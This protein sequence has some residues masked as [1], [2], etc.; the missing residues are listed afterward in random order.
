LSAESLEDRRMMAVY[1]VT[2]LGDGP[3]T[4]AGQQPGT[5]RQAIFD[6]NW[7]SGADI[8]VF[9]PNLTGTIA[10]AEG[11]LAITDPLTLTGPGADKITIDA[12]SQGGVSGNR[13]LMIAVPDQEIRTTVSGLTITGG[14]LGDDPDVDHGGGILVVGGYVL[15]SELIVAG[16][17]VGTGSSENFG[18][19]FASGGGIAV[20]AT[21]GDN[22]VIENVVVRNNVVSTGVEAVNRGGGGG[23]AIYNGYDQWEFSDYLPDD[24]GSAGYVEISNSKIVENTAGYIV[25]DIDHPNSRTVPVGVGGGILNVI[26]NYANTSASSL[27]RTLIK[28]SEIADNTGYY[29]GGG[30]FTTEGG[31]GTGTTVEIINS[32][33]SGNKA[34]QGGGI[35]AISGGHYVG[36]P[37]NLRTFIHHSTITDNRAGIYPNGIS[38]P[39]QDPTG[40]GLFINSGGDGSIF[41][42]GGPDFVIG[43][44]LDHSIVAGNHQTDD[45]TNV[46]EYHDPFLDGLGYAPDIGT[47]GS[48]RIT[49]PNLPTPVSILNASYSL[50]GSSFGPINGLI[51]DAETRSTQF[52]ISGAGYVL[53]ASAALGVLKE[54]GGTELPDG[55]RIRT[56]AL[57]TGSAAIDAGNPGLTAG[58]DAPLFDQRGAPFDRIYDGDGANGARIDIGAFERQPVSVAQFDADFNNDESVD[59]ADFIIWQ[60]HYGLAPNAL[61]EEGDADFDGNVDS[62]DLDI[63]KLQF[64]YF[65]PLNFN[66]DFNGDGLV[67]GDDFVVWVAGF[68]TVSGGTLATGD[69]NGDGTVNI[70]D[71]RAWQIAYSGTLG[72]I[73]DNGTNPQYADLTVGSILVSS[74]EDEND[75]DYRLGRLSLREAIAVASTTGISEIAFASGLF[76]TIDLTL[77]YLTIADDLNIGGPGADKL[78]INA[79]GLSRVFYVN[80]GVEATIS[81]MTITGGLSTGGGGGIY[82]NGDL[83][84]DSV[85]VSGNET[86]TYGGGVYV[87]GTGALLVKDSTFDD[88]HA[89]GT[90]GNAG[91]GAI[92]GTFKSGLSL[93]ISNSTFSNN[94]ASSVSGASAGGAIGIYGLTST[95]A[96]EIANSTFSGNSAAVAG[97]IQLNSASGMSGS[98]VNSTIAYNSATAGAAGGIYNANATVTLHNSILAVNTA[99]NTTYHDAGGVSLSAG[100]VSSYNIIGQ[101][102]ASGLSDGVAGNQVGTLVD[103]IDPLLAPLGEYGGK[104]KTHALKVGSPALDKGKGSL[105]DLYDQRGFNR[106]FDL[107]D[108]ANGGDGYRDIGAYEAGVQTTL[109]VR[110]SGDRNDSISSSATIDSLRLREALAL[111]AA[112]AGREIITFDQSLLQAGPATVTLSVDGPDSG[113]IP[114][115]LTL[116][117]ADIVGPGAD[118]L[119]ISG[120][121]QQ[122]VVVATGIAKISGVTITN[123]GGQSGG[124]VFADGIVE[125]NSARIVGN[126]ATTGGGGIYSY[127]ILKVFNSEISDNTVTGWNGVGG[128]GAGIAVSQYNSL[129]G[130]YVYNSTISGNSATG[131]NSSGGGISVFA[132][133]PWLWDYRI[134]SST[135]TDNYASFGS[136]VHSSYYMHTAGDGRYL[137]VA[138]SI[139][140]DNLGGGDVSGNL[141]TLST[142][143]LLRSGAAGGLSTNNILLSGG[144]TARLGELAFNGS[145]TRTHVPYFDSLAIDAGNS[146]LATSFDLDFDQRGL[147]RVVD[148]QS[149]GDSTDEIDIGAVELAFSE[150]YYD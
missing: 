127:G 117:D 71:L 76:G 45:A 147:A 54:N 101:V 128:G 146:S 142:H 4:A 111:S 115:S 91:H 2:N 16:N 123:G 15:L 35:A 75:G 46:T 98:I 14:R 107:T 1:E 40:G 51:N 112:L 72:D 24:S 62:A 124:G 67:D 79:G 64:G 22:V 13:A 78:T 122:S 69:A 81:G 139:I 90:T 59:G 141:S 56:H 18:P 11:E 57:L 106:E 137:Y 97:A 93:Q 104:T 143:N 134:V 118:L 145:A 55:S 135:I 31:I 19:S 86:N 125:I 80:S 102:G 9:A 7:T 133:D 41:I 89:V 105:T 60:A 58:L 6:A 130:L 52:T 150:L 100:G 23:I 63:W 28:N 70:S 27:R 29:Q 43:V 26:G 77:G 42:S 33:I 140:A 82:N 30:I 36:D 119:T 20:F 65:E 84:L 25:N 53:G 136:G 44:V 21:E 109:V 3:V 92:G 5:L 87:S 113:S 49:D 95:T 114:D 10:L 47:D 110:N 129:Y 74:L 83:T 88:N 12:N 66:A 96:F 38:H 37:A 120:T 94:S 34:T 50:I 138:N 85:V 73:Y 32:T 68:G 17:S 48:A 99:S 126:T 103:R 121:G 39:S 8:I 108:V 148:H 131:S 132:Y 61:H 144:A 116:T 149:D